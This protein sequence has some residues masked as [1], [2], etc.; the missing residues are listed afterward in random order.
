M[1]VV[2]GLLAS[3]GFV[4]WRHYREICA[5]RERVADLESARPVKLED[6]R[7]RIAGY[8]QDR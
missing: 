7:R 5:L 8:R 6:P 2:L 1:I 4:V 3:L